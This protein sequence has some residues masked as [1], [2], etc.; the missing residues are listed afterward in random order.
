MSL[1]GILWGFALSIVLF[2]QH[3]KHNLCTEFEPVLKQRHFRKAVKL[4]LVFHQLVENLLLLI[5]QGFLK[6]A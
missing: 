4:N 1:N 5:G 2:H 3:F 6:S